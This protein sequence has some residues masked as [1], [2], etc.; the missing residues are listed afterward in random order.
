M[1]KWVEMHLCCPVA[2]IGEFQDFSGFLLKQ[3]CNDTL[4]TSRTNILLSRLTKKVSDGLQGLI[5]R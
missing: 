3:S 2:K 5:G 1:P 4:S